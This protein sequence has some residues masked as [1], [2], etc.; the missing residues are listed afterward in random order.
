VACH[1]DRAT[2]VKCS[3]SKWKNH[4]IQGRVAEPVW[5]YVS[6]QEAGSTCG[7]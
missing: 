4:L 3:S 5:E 7:W 1:R 6:E 2:K